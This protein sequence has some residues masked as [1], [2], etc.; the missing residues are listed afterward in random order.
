MDKNVDK[1]EL[2]CKPVMSVSFMERIPLEHAIEVE[3][4]DVH[5]MY[6]FVASNLWF[7]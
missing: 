3:N 1:E 4:K 6:L 7:V 2:K 5:C